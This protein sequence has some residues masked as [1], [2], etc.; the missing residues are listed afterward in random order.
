MQHHLLYLETTVAPTGVLINSELNEVTVFK[1]ILDLVDSFS[2][3]IKDF[4]NH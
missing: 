3:C 4:F 1:E 2:H